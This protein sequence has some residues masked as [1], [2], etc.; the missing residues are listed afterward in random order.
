MRAS[1]V[2]L[3]AGQAF[4]RARSQSDTCLAV[5]LDKFEREEQISER[6]IQYLHGLTF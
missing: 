6:F 2:V 4:I 1:V 5:G 3:F